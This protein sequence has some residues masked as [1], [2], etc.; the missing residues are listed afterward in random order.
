MSQATSPENLPNK[1]NLSEAE[2][3]GD[4]G[5]TIKLDQ[6]LKLAGVVRSGGEA[7]IVIQSGQ[8]TVN[9]HV[10]TRRGRKLRHGDVVVAR[11]E[12]LVML[13]DEEEM[14]EEYQE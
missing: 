8:V 7:K 4:T 9:G 3:T 6:F 2:T 5:E 1:A 11:G 10:E 13:S 14:P 12:E